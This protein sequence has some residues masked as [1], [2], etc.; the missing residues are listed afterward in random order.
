MEKSNE[1]FVQVRKPLPLS[2]CSGNEVVSEFY[3]M[4]SKLFRVFIMDSPPIV[5]TSEG[6]FLPRILLRLIILNVNLSI[7]LYPW[8]MSS[9]GYPLDYQHSWYGE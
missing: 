8:P 4:L 5:V 2:F 3:E 7:L 9:G 1:L 6:F